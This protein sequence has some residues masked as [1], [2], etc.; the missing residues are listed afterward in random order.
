MNFTKELNFGTELEVFLPRKTFGYD[1]DWENT[2]YFLLE[3]L[4]ENGLP[5]NQS[6]DPQPDDYSGWK[7]VRDESLELTAD[8]LSSGVF[9]E[10]G[11]ELVSPR[12]KGEEGLEQVAI[13]LKTA[14]E[15]RAH[16]NSTC[17]YHVHSG[18]CNS[19]GFP[20]SEA[21]NFIRCVTQSSNIETYHSLIDPR[22]IGSEACRGYI[23]HYFGYLDTA[24]YCSAHLIGPK[25]WLGEK[26]CIINMRNAKI[27]SPTAQTTHRKNTLEWRGKEAG[28]FEKIT[29]HVAYTATIVDFTANALKTPHAKLE[30]SVSKF[31]QTDFKTPKRRPLSYRRS[32]EQRAAMI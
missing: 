11:F 10:E 22:R 32:M 3:R 29:P 7:I 2:A 4:A 1:L 15:F 9:I 18:L 13:L 31:K 28:G 30:D 6:L 16:T 5:I 12:L 20:R 26:R 24:D 17:G 25:N 19:I 8:E 27:Y 14:A 23:S 21:E